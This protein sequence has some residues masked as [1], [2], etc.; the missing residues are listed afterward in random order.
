MSQENIHVW[1]TKDALTKG[2]QERDGEYDS[3]YPRMFVVKAKAGTSNL[4]DQYYHNKEW[5]RTKELALFQAEAM[6]L[7]KI[8]SLERT[9]TKLKAI[10]FQSSKRLIYVGDNDHEP[11]KSGVQEI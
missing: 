7:A 5:H 6:R 2:I 3:E 10:K 4:Y 11:E 8:K 9:L 1:I